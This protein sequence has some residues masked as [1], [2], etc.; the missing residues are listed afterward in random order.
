MEFRVE[1][2]RGEAVGEG[3]SSRGKVNWYCRGEQQR[4]HHL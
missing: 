1:V 3:I 4:E 2:G